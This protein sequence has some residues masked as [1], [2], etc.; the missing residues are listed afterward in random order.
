MMHDQAD[1]ND[2]KNKVGNYFQDHKIEAGCMV[3]MYTVASHGG[4]S[5]FG[6]DQ[7]V[8]AYGW[9]NQPFGL[10]GRAGSWIDECKY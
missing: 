3:P 4:S 5:T 7:G 2:M 10:N 9:N 8:L 1:M 6:V